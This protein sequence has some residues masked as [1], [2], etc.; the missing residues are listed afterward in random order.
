MTSK[1]QVTIPKVIAERYAIEP[2]SDVFFEPAGETIRV[3]LSEPARPAAGAARRLEL[4]DR[5]TE[6]QLARETAEPWPTPV[7]R[8]RDWRREDLYD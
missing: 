5:A 3:R 4:F 7:E 2:G 6:R 8:D 1:L